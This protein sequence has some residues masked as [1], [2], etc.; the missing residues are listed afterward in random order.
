MVRPLGVSFVVAFLLNA[1]LASGADQAADP[2][3]YVFDA[4]AASRE[5]LPARTPAAGS[6]WTMLPEDELAHTF[7]G[8]AVLLNNAMRIVL[9]PGGP[10]ATIEA[11]QGDRLAQR[12]VL[13][14]CPAAADGTPA[15]TGLRLLENKRS[16]V[17]IEATFRWD[18]GKHAS[19]VFRL[20]A[21]AGFV[22]ARAGQGTTRLRVRARVSHVVVPDFFAGDL[23]FGG[24]V[25]DRSFSGA[26][27][28]GRVG[29]PAENALLALVDGAL[30]VGVWPSS[31]RSADL[32]VSSDAAATPAILGYEVECAKGQGTWVAPLATPGIW[33]RLRV[34]A[35]GTPL[36][37]VAAWKR[38]FPA[39]WRAS[40]I[41][42]GAS[43]DTWDLAARQPPTWASRRGE[44]DLVVYPLD[45]SRATPLNVLCPIDVLRNVLGMG[46]CQYILDAE[47]LG[48][49]A[50]P[51]PDVVTRWIEKQ[52]A[53][54]RD[55]RR[56]DEIKERLRLMADHLG[57]VAARIGQY[58]RWAGRMHAVRPEG[59]TPSTR[60]G[61]RSMTEILDDLQ[62]DLA[63]GDRAARAHELAEP[64]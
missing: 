51:A 47:G 31:R 9:A 63:A 37:A 3:T 2:S 62:Q 11:G 12:A 21:G 7:A 57:R 29:V 13:T 24:D 30:L 28:R 14:P 20:T 38:P 44:G 17:A 18:D 58:G 48:S 39:K 41:H 46:P 33:S 10:G 4:G 61:W 54:G 16:A 49:E 23:V 19:A 1:T 35:N 22:E 32:I 36:E 60:R 55:A 27:A 43:A 6:A 25:G 56:A 64:L 53:R 5:P 59:S 50:N 45:R 42:A 40:P 52:F 8:H 15:M 26:T 34:P